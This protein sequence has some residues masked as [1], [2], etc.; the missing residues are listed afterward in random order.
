[1]KSFEGHIV[2][3]LMRKNHLEEDILEIC[4]ISDL[5]MD[6][7]KDSINRS[8][9]FTRKINTLI[10][11]SFGFLCRGNWEMF[12]GGNYGSPITNKTKKPNSIG[13]LFHIFP[14]LPPSIYIPPFSSLFSHV[15]QRGR[16]TSKDGS[17]LI[18][19]PRYKKNAERYAELYEKRF[20]KCVDIT[21]SED[22]AYW[23]A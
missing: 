8:S 14:P 6:I 19:K 20:K 9:Y 17:S 16:F 2:K 23:D 3:K 11:K 1:M 4:R 21:V 10:M 13:I 5:D 15:F 7:V 12:S 22:F 18:V